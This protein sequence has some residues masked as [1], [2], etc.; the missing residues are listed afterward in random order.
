MNRAFAKLNLT[1]QEQRLVVAIA[2]VVF[3]VLNVWFVWPH[4]KDLSRLKRQQ[5]SLEADL[6][7]YKKLI[8]QGPT[9]TQELE[10][11]RS[12][13][14]ELPTEAQAL[15]LVKT[16]MSQAAM[17]GVTINNYTPSRSTVAQTNQFFE[18][19]MLQINVN[20]GEKELVDF[21]YGLSS[22]SSLIRVK[23]MSLQP[24]QPR[25]RLGGAITLVASYQRQTPLKPAVAAAPAPTK[26]SSLPPPRTAA[27]A[28]AK[29][30]VAS[31]R[32]TLPT[33][34]L[35]KT[36]TNKIPVRPTGTPPKT[37]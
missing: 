24:D 16:V 18:E 2:L 36:L 20:T 9:F 29:T 26:S 34:L 23:S 11:L 21:L 15:E 30:N 19:Q 6:V 3:V 13:G 25:M 28:S 4:F 31:P 37:K 32:T 8:E 22:G 14:V 1:S 10:K 33:N 27:A 7:R 5:Q 17:S 12:L 35:G